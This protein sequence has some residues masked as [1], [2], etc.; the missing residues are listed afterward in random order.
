MSIPLLVNLSLPSSAEVG[1]QVQA[2]VTWGGTVPP[3]TCFINWGDG[4]YTSSGELGGTSFT[5]THVYSAA[6]TYSVT[7]D[8]SDYIGGFGYD[9]A[10]IIITEVGP[11]LDGSLSAN[12]T[13]GTAPLNVTFTMNVS[14]GVAPY[15]WSLDFGDASTPLSGSRTVAGS[16]TTS[17]IYSAGTFTAVLTITDS[18]GV[19]VYQRQYLW[20]PLIM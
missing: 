1:E 17:H 5:A 4:Q 12:P 8:V 18:A 20:T 2:Q 15:N 9:S 11:P 16:W 10:S 19:T 3:Y 14:G 13:S 7:A 6:D